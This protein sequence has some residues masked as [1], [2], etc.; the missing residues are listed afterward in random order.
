MKL[1]RIDLQIVFGYS[2]SYKP[3]IRNQC[4]FWL[5]T[6]NGSPLYI[7]DTIYS[8]S[9]NKF[10]AI[11]KLLGLVSNLGFINYQLLIFITYWI[12]ISDKTLKHSKNRNTWLPSMILQIYRQLTYSLYHAASPTILKCVIKNITWTVQDK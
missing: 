12:L 2:M 4:I 6:K 1:A 11:L 7:L 5:H 9:V 8:L 10:Y 3:M